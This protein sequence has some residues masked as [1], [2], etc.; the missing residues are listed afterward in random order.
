MDLNG[1]IYS[2]YKKNSLEIV[3]LSLSLHLHKA[4]EGTF[5]N[6]LASAWFKYSASDKYFNE[7]SSCTESKG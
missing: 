2:Y 1:A 4:D 3:R 7:I 5:Y 6:S